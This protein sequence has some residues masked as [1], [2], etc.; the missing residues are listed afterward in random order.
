MINQ[1][2]LTYYSC[3]ILFL[4]GNFLYA[5]STIK[6]IVTDSIANPIGSANVFLKDNST[7]A[8]TSFAYTNQKGEY[9]LQTNEIGEVTLS[10]SGLG[11]A[12]KD[13]KI[14]VKEN[15]EIEHN[16][17]LKATSYEL[18][19]V[20]IASEK[21]ITEKKDTIVFN[22]SSFKQGE[23]TVIQDLLKKLPGVDVSETGTIK[24]DGREVEKVMVEGDDFFKK[25]YK[26]LTKNLNVEAVDK[27][28]VL[29]RYSNNKLLKGI[30]ESEKV[31]LNLK[32]DEDF[33]RQWFGSVS[34][35]Y[36]V[37]SENRYD[38][39][40]NV[41]SFGKKNKYFLLGSINNIG[42]DVTDDVRGLINAQNYSDEPGMVGESQRAYSFIKLNAEVPGLKKT[43]TNFNN[44]ELVSLNS[45]FKL[46]SKVNFKVLGLFNSDNNKFFSQGFTSFTG[47]TTSFTNTENYTL[48]KTTNVGF[49]RVELNYDIS[50]TQ[51]FEYEG[52]FNTSSVN[53][54]TELIFNELENNERLED[55]NQLHDHMIKYSNRFKSNKVLLVTGRYIN[56][57]KPQ[58]YT[59]NQFLFT[60][61]FPSTQ[62]I[63]TV[64]QLNKNKFNY[65]GFKGHML[66]RRKNKDLLDFSVGYEFRKDRLRSDL[67]FK[68]NSTVLNAPDEYMNLS[69][70]TT[71]DLYITSGYRKKLREVDIAINIEGHQLFNQLKETDKRQ[72]ESPFL[73][74]TKLNFSW[75]IDKAN[76]LFAYVENVNSNANVSD[77]YSNYLLT[78]YRSFLRG[79]GTFNQLNATRVFTGY[80]LGNFG[81]RFTANIS[82]SYLKDNDFLSTN[83]II[84][85]NFVQTTKLIIP[86]REFYS[87][88]VNLDRYLRFIRNNIKL[89]LSYSLAEFKNIVNS[90]NLRLVESEEC[91]YGFEIRSG[92]RGIFNYHVGTTWNT[93]QIRTSIKNAATQNISFID[94]SFVLSSKFNIQLQSE[95]YFFN[96]L[97]DDNDTYYFMDF[98]VN[99]KPK[100]KGVS[101]SLIGNNLLNR[102][103]YRDYNVT[104][105][106]ISSASYRLLPRYVLLKANY[107]F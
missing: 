10:F 90:T 89:K 56:E 72:K 14:T 39:E 101:F 46:S 21:A 52:K 83:S 50:E 17:V 67:F 99:Y 38:I 11:Y 92:F 91:K 57:E 31:A 94:L 30:E 24:V 44:A 35:G 43:R 41:S 82:L 47:N 103:N 84:T 49:G 29:R 77:I 19:E 104:D 107:K 65:V 25:G 100:S 13:I 61:L 18:D 23:E 22:V 63:N 20:I 12:T 86:D 40:S 75:E 98:E 60:E 37:V 58:E 85:Q 87:A 95:R 81:D 7:N 1:K 33:K 76:R 42:E 79:T 9:V 2:T 15:E 8:I 55:E 51:L 71:H 80:N 4:L 69:R 66:D 70:Y 96:N 6:G 106:F 3:L 53:T 64:R 68:E 102:D 73:V 105:T 34:P 78:G 16:A 59:T 54:S 93:T 36:G 62:N 26:L 32:L 48:G 88:S 74:N 97:D 45:I 27:V 5:Q 28:E